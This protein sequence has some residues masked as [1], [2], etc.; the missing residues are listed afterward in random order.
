M[1]V[2]FFRDKELEKELYILVKKELKLNGLH[3]D[4]AITPELM[5]ACCNRLLENKNDLQNFN[6]LNLNITT[7]YS[8]L[9]NGVVCIP[10]NWNF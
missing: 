4:D 10:W 2:Y 1:S 8:V 6:N 3:K 5:I 9:T 7:Y